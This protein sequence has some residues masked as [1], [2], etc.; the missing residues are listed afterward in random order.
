MSL[1]CVSYQNGSEQP[2]NQVFS[3]VTSPSLQ[4]TNVSV[5]SLH[6]MSKLRFVSPMNHY[7][8]PSL[9]H[10]I[11]TKMGIPGNF[12]VVTQDEKHNNYVVE[13]IYPEPDK[14]YPASPSIL[15]ACHHCCVTDMC[16]FSWSPTHCNP[17]QSSGFSPSCLQMEWTPRW[18]LQDLFAQTL[19]R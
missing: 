14:L 16:Y 15:S 17:S 7:F 2:H 6:S 11:V 12:T 19:R 10:C 9:T 18:D 5:D 3:C 4:R 13:Q 8:A 1:V